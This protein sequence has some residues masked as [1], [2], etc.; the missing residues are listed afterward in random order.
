MALSFLRS[1]QRS[2]FKLQH[3]IRVITSNLGIH[4]F[5]S[6]QWLFTPKISIGRNLIDDKPEVCVRNG[7]INSAY[8]AASLHYIR[9][10]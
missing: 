6:R 2:M 9:Q 8:L 5:S 3:L 10:N 1:S 7:S 4:L